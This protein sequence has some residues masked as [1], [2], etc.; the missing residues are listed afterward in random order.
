MHI[1]KIMKLLILLVVVTVVLGQAGHEGERREE[2]WA[3]AVDKNTTEQG[4]AGKEGSIKDLF[5]QDEVEFASS[6]YAEIKVRKN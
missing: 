1:V 5:L 6:E 3:G 2:S 4:G